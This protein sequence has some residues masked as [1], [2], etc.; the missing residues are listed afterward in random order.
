MQHNKSSKKIALKML[1]VL[2]CFSNFLFFFLILYFIP[3]FS[4]SRKFSSFSLDGIPV[5]HFSP[6]RVNN[7]LC[8]FCMW[9]WASSQHCSDLVVALKVAVQQHL[10]CYFLVSCFCPLDPLWISFTA[11]TLDIVVPLIEITGVLMLRS[12]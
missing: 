3:P 6:L 5:V 11:Q 4:A 8:K 9:S 1:S 10:H 12:S 2:L 7:F